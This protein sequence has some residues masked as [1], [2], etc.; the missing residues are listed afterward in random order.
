MR[1][2]IKKSFKKFLQLFIRIESIPFT[3]NGR[4]AEH[5]TLYIFGFSIA[6]NV[7]NLQ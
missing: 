6:S 3:N 4:P 1:K 5:C 7:F 2:S